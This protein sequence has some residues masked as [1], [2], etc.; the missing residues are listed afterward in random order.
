VCTSDL[1][2]LLEGNL[3]SLYE[4]RLDQQAKARLADH[5]VLG[6]YFSSDAHPSTVSLFRNHKERSTIWKARAN[7]AGVGSKLV[8][9]GILDQHDKHARCCCQWN[10][11]LAPLETLDH[12][13]F[14]CPLL[15]R[16]AEPARSQPTVQQ[17]LGFISENKT[18]PCKPFLA[19]RVL[20]ATKCVN[21]FL[22]LWTERNKIRQERLTQGL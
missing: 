1:T 3:A 16:V 21:S 4:Q 7:V 13:I 6:L 19:D 11:P 10:D 5:P 17:A 8:E 15:A 22:E 18:P 9:W 12:L 14:H 20:A 2:Q